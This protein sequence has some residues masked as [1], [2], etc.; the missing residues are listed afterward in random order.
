MKQIFKITVMTIMFMMSVIVEAQEIYVLNAH[1]QLEALEPAST[2]G[3]KQTNLVL[4][5]YSLIVDGKTS[6][7]TLPCE[8]IYFYVTTEA[9]TNVKSWKLVPLKK[10]KGNFR[11]LPYLKSKP[12][13]QGGSTSY[14]SSTGKYKNNSNIGM[15]QYVSLKDLPLRYEKIAVGLYKV[16]PTEKVKPGEYALIRMEN[17]EPA[18]VYDFI[19]DKSLSS[20]LNVPSNDSVIA[21]IGSREE[22]SPG[23]LTHNSG[24]TLLAGSKSRASE[25]DTDIPVRKGNAENTFALIISNENYKRVENVPFAYNDGNIFEQYLRLTLGVSDSHI[26]HMQDA[27]LTDIKFGLNRIKEI[28]EAFDGKA[29]II[30]HYSGHGI[31]DEKNKDGYLLPIDGYATDPSTAY[32]LSEFYKDLDNINAESVIVFMDAC[33]SGSQKTG[34]MISS[35]RGVSIKVN[36][37]KPKG[38]L[39]VMS[40]AQGDQTAYPYN[41]KEH[42]LMTYF[43]LKKLQD[44]KGMVSLGE[45][46]DYVIE[47][48]K[49]TSILENGKSQEPT[50]ICGNDGID[51]R[52][53]SLR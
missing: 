24:S 44:S 8:A 31:P 17:E 45:L 49:K 25:V 47:N 50:V 40:A 19:V 38:N 5:A 35:A 21:N 37:E 12:T 22:V 10:G 43:V 53:T 6:D 15:E 33:F 7:L 13:Y 48:V 27:S 1:S 11:L 2:S 42:G 34:H 39:I 9:G 3:N 23:S 4:P 51:W 52:N 18:E 28:C 26:T 46:S 36:E 32:K 29:K 30:V 41:E 16:Y 20:N 14:D